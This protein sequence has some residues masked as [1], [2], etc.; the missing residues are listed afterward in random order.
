MQYTHHQD[1]ASDG[2]T[3]GRVIADYIQARRSQ[4]ASEILQAR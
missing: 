1:E 3:H 2:G 4:L